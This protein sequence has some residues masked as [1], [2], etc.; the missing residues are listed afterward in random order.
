MSS[1]R[2]S[3]EHT[4]G[5]LRGGCDGEDNLDRH[6]RQR[7]NSNPTQLEDQLTELHTGDRH[8]EIGGW[9]AISIAGLDLTNQF[10]NS[11]PVPPW[12]PLSVVT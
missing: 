3:A 2:K 11:M 5:T 4:A 7:Q 12:F 9:I 8:M 10:S 1:R 6:K